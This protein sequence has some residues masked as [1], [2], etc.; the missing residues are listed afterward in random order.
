LHT[1]ECHISI[2][3]DDGNEGPELKLFKTVSTA[4]AIAQVVVEHEAASVKKGNR[5]FL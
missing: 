3:E 5:S 4:A 2:L 1:A